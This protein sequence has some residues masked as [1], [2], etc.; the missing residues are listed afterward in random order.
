MSEKSSIKGTLIP[1][2]GAEDK[3]EHEKTRDIFLKKGILSHVLRESG[4]VNSR[5]VVIPTASRIPVE[6]GENYVSGFNMLGC[7]NVDVINI[8]SKKMAEDPAVMKKLEEADGIM[9]SGGNQARISQ[10]IGGTL[11][12]KLLQERYVNDTL[13]IAGTSAGAMAMAQRMIAGGSSS[14]ALVKG[15]VKMRAGLGLIPE[16]IIDTHFVRRGR[17]GRLAE[18]VAAYPKLL[19]IGIAE[20]TGV[21]IKNGREFTV[22][23]SG[24]VMVMDPSGLTHNTHKLLK[25][26]TP[27]SLSNLTVHIL[28]NGDHFTLDNKLVEVLPIE[29]SFV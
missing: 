26:G 15:A 14:E 16:L 2:G 13:V 18:A 11:A 17:F 27:M 21:V 3:G 5:I 28:A 10:K 22:I 24:L 4:G 12:H 23:G 25:Q 6:V 8:T 20:D 29:K 19:G 9:F 7:T 1:I